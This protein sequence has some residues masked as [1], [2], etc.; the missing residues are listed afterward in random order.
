[1]RATRRLK[2]RL[3]LL[4]RALPSASVSARVARPERRLRRAPEDPHGPDPDETRVSREDEEHGDRG[5]GQG[6]RA[7]RTGES[8]GG[9]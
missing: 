1:L 6:A 8:R 7:Q 4:V 9:I 3:S 2:K 5:A